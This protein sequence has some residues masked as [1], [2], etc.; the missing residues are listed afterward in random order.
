MTAAPAKVA[1]NTAE[2]TTTKNTASE[3]D[4]NMDCRD[5]IIAKPRD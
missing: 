4:E 2:K 5:S 3:F 1:K